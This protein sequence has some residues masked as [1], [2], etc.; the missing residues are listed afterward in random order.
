MSLAHSSSGAPHGSLAWESTKKSPSFSLTRSPSPPAKY[1]SY[2]VVT[3]F[4]PCGLSVSGSSPNG[5]AR[6][7]STTQSAPA[8]ALGAVQFNVPVVDPPWY[9]SVLVPVRVEV[10]FLTED[11]SSDTVP[12]AAHG[13]V[14]QR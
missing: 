2:A 13:A 10:R 4:V 12:V 5:T 6:K 11:R 3:S 9:P 1:E 8:G 14:V 7:V